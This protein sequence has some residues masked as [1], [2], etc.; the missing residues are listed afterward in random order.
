VIEKGKFE[1]TATSSVYKGP[2]MNRC[3]QGVAVDGAGRVWVVTYRRQIRPEEVIRI[4]MSGNQSGSTV[5]REGNT[6]LRTTDMFQLDVLDSEGLLLGSLP[7]TQFIDGIWIYGD[8][9]YLLDRDHGV[10]YHQYRIVER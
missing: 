5:K 6:D 4:S 9:L 8:R 2:T 3:S 1:R 7:V 10:A